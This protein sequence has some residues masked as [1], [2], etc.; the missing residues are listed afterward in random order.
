VQAQDAQKKLEGKK[1][2]TKK[3]L[4]DTESLMKLTLMFMKLVLKVK[5]VLMPKNKKAMAM[6]TQSS[7][8][9]HPRR[10]KVNEAITKRRRDFPLLSFCLL[11]SQ[12]FC[13]PFAFLVVKTLS[14]EVAQPV[15]P[16]A[17]F[18]GMMPLFR[19]F[20]LSCLA[21]CWLSWLPWTWLYLKML[22]NYLLAFGRPLVASV[23][24]KCLLF[25]LGH[26]TK[27]PRSLVHSTY[28]LYHE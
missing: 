11:G 16:L 7:G 23:L 24:L 9:A 10:N 28:L 25:S 5:V 4:K 22:W 17:G 15:P 19:T 21:W 3:K 12:V 13:I 20:W 14:L 8:M 6:L 2:V 27:F 26:I 18:E 1:K